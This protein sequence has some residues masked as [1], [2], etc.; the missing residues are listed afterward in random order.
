MEIII[1][2][3]IL[4][5]TGALVCYINYGME[6]KIRKRDIQYSEKIVPFKKKVRTQPRK[7]KRTSR[8]YTRRY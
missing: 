1:A 7:R 6:L 3:L 2:G 8:Y 5:V 4:M